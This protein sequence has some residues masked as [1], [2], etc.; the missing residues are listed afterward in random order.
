[1]KNKIQRLFVRGS[2]LLGLTLIF[3]LLHASIA[4]AAGASPSVLDRFKPD[5][6][7][8]LLAGEVVYEFIKKNTPDGKSGGHGQSYILIN[9][10]IDE[11]WKMFCEFDK[12]YQYFPRKTVS[13]VLQS[14]PTSALIQNEFNFYVTTIKYT[15]RYT[16]NQS[17]HRIDFKMD[18]KYPHDIN[19]T[20]GFF[21]F[22]KVDDKRCLF[23]YGATLVDTGL[24][25]PAFIQDYLTSKDL[26]TQA[27][28]VKKRLESK[29]KWVKDE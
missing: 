2:R 1:M 13:K 28:N 23:T 15:V 22:E 3:T 21:L 20:A 9:V 11:A 29:G 8:K 17:A 14:S 26:P 27:L 19:D 25:V 5:Q 7:Q 18:P 24:Q 16:I 12:Q 6:K 4:L 10:P